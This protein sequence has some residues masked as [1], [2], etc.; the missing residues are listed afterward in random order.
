MGLILREREAY[1]QA[2]EYF[3]QAISLDNSNEIYYRN[4]GKSYY[5]QNRYTPFIEDFQMDI[6]LKS[7]DGDIVVDLADCY[8]WQEES[9]YEKA[10][11]AYK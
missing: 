2:I 10:E 3:R 9:A 1:D 11:E 8:Y 4:L 7:T 6:E 5:D